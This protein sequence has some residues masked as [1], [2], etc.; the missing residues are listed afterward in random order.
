MTSQNKLT[1]ESCTGLITICEK[2]EGAEFASVETINAAIREIAANDAP[3]C[4]AKVTIL[5]ENLRIQLE[6]RQ[7]EAQ[8]FELVSYVREARDF[9][10]AMQPD[11]FWT[12][13]RVEHNRVF[14]TAALAAVSA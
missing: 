10:T 3:G 5:V 7:L 2:Y 12:V 11:G 9:W 13:E 8:S 1:I 14:W 6:I 4:C